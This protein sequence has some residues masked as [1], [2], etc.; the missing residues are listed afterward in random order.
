[1]SL[2]KN[3]AA[4]RGNIKTQPFTALVIHRSSSRL[5]NVCKKT[6]TVTLWGLRKNSP[7]KLNFLLLEPHNN[8]THYNHQGLVG[9]ISGHVAERLLMLS[10]HRVL[11]NQVPG[12]RVPT[13][14]AV[15]LPF[16]KRDR[17]LCLH[18]PHVLQSPMGDQAFM[19]SA[20]GN[21]PHNAAL[22]PFIPHIIYK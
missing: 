5:W 3:N 1:M 9:M 22:S 20:L 19:A 8:A 2:I 6:P 16:L 10:L 14:A 4:K 12:L 7:K 15:A 21:C 11:N 18:T 17:W 13:A